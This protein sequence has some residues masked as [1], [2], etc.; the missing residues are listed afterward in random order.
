MKYFYTKS[1]FYNSVITPIVTGL[2]F[3]FIFLLFFI[4]WGFYAPIDS[5]SISEGNIIFK[6]N[7]KKVFCHGESLYINKILV[8]DGDFVRK[9]EP[10]II[11][12]STK[13]KSDLQ[14]VLWQLRYSILVD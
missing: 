4:I 11:F 2:I 5:A 13:I 7:V 12:D 14:K 6:N 3:I 8:K 9:G 1:T 10:L